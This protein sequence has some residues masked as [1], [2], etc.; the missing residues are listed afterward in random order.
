MRLFDLVEEDHG[1]RPAPDR[2]RELAP[3]LIAHVSGR[4]ADQP[5]HRVLFHV[6]G[7]VDPDQIG[8]IIEQSG[9]Q[10]AR[11]LGLSDSRGTQKEK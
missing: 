5:G 9:G 7:H 8:L 4:S 11:Q 10:R 6:L 1:E 3:F 2:L